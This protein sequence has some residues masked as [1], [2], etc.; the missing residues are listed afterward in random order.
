MS[1]ASKDEL[2]KLNKTDLIEMIIKLQERNYDEKFEML[3][4]ELTKLT[5][6]HSFRGNL[7]EK[8]VEE[9]KKLSEENKKL[10]IRLDDIDRYNRRNNI[11][12]HGIPE[13]ISKD[14][15]QDTVIQLGKKI[16][17]II[18][19]QD[20]EAVHR[21]KKSPNSKA[22]ARV[23]AR[24]VNRRTVEKLIESRKQLKDMNL[25]DINLKKVLITN[26][27]CP[28]YSKLY[29]MLHKLYK[30]KV[31][32]SCWSFNGLVYYK[33]SENDKKGKLVRNEDDILSVFGSHFADR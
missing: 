30:N 20:F 28:S 11:E 1:T 7:L 10:A 23:I 6:A 3:H 15:L 4:I 26:N 31:I 32:N 5:E 21:L 22:P 19:E 29:N 16:D 13:N 33:L 25:D 24:F 27:L 9:N 17:V 14:E 2:K 8:L 18:N 12:F